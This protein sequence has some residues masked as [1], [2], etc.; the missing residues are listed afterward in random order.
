MPSRAQ[1]NV[2]P[3]SAPRQVDPET[4]FAYLARLPP[5]VQAYLREDAPI[6]WAAED[7]FFVWEQLGR[8]TGQLLRVL[9]AEG[10]NEINGGRAEANR[11][12]LKL[13]PVTAYQP[14]RRVPR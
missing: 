3:V 7:V 6:D 10:I 11:H 9:Y 1:G 2:G 13:P 12:G 8:D 14:V 4:E 5:R